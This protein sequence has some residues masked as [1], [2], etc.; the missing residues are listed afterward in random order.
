M[1][2][3]ASGTPAHAL[4]T[5]VGKPALVASAPRA[6]SRPGRSGGSTWR[7][8]STTAAEYEAALFHLERTG[9]RGALR[10]ARHL[11]A[12][13]AQE[14]ACTASPMTTPSFVPWH[15]LLNEITGDAA[16]EDLVLAEIEAMGPDG[17]IRP[18]AARAVRHAAHRAAGDEKQRRQWRRT[19]TCTVE[20]GFGIDVRG[21]WEEIVRQMKDRRPPN[22]PRLARTVHGGERQTLAKQTGLAIPAT[23]LRVPPRRR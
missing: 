11:A 13:R 21:N 16:P 7:N 3:P 1:R 14:R 12:R 10:R 18:A 4:P 20:Y 22:G 8:C 6:R 23:T 15:D 19:E 17:Q 5:R 9:P 2:P